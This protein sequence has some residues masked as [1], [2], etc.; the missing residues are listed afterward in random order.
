M[1]FGSEFEAINFEMDGA[2]AVI[3]LNRPDNANSLNAQMS[4]ELLKAA[5]HC[6]SDPSIRA[7]VFTGAG[8][9]VFCGRRFACISC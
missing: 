8:K 6:D 9:D 4:E 7:V 1:K 5:T 3:T 2:V